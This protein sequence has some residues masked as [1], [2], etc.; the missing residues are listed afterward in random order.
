MVTLTVNG[1]L[2]E[3]HA[4]FI[5]GD[6]RRSDGIR[7]YDGTFTVTQTGPSTVTYS[8]TGTNSTISGGTM[9]ISPALAMVPETSDAVIY[10]GVSSIYNWGAF[11]WNT[12]MLNAAG[13]DN[14][15]TIY[16]TGPDPN[17]DS[18]GF[19][20][21]AMRF[22]ITNTTAAPSTR[23]WYDYEFLTGTTVVLPND[24]VNNP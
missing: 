8:N 10:G 18:N 3:L 1:T 14:T 19:L 4:D 9:T 11:Q 13:Q 21:D 16:S 12:S 17:G 6:N 5:F 22:E 23:G 24:A 7:P 20:L 2:Q 15:I